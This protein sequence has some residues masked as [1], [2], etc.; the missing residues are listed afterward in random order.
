MAR[1]KTRLAAF[2]AVIPP[3]IPAPDDPPVTWGYARV[4]T[5]EQTTARQLD[6]LASAGIPAGRVVQEA[7]SGGIPARARPRLA[8]LLAV[9]RPGDVLAALAV[10]R[11][12]RDPA[13]VLAL[14]RDLTG[15]GV[16]L[17]LLG[18]GIET[19]T[20]TGDLVLGVLATV[21]GWERSIIKERTRQGLA[22]ARLRGKSLGRRPT[23]LPPQRQHARTL[24]AQGTP[25]REIARIL[26][27]SSSIAHRAVQEVPA[28]PIGPA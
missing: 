10:D 28:V 2:S 26:G 9:L 17:R 22:A 6:A 11:L 25:V 13:D 15:Q 18:M 23:L 24:A 27:C 3:G 8:G 16:R 5:D 7:I 1:R 4:S 21:A 19:G 20:P 12:G 14:A